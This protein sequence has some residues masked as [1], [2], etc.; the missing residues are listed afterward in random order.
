MNMRTAAAAIALA[1]LCWIPLPAATP[2]MPLGEVKAGMVGIG[3]TVFEGAKL[4]EFNVHILGVLHNIQ[5][6]H[7][8]LILA[9]LEGGPL[10]KTGVAA[11][12]SGSP[13]YIDGRLIGAVSYSIGSFPTEAIAGITPIDEMKDATA[14]VSRTPTR[15][16]RIDLPITRE[17]LTNAL[18]ATYARLAPFAN[19]PADIQVFG[20]PAAAG[21]Q[22][23]AMLRPIATPLVMSGF[24][25]GA[26][27]MLA[28][29][30]GAAG[31]TPVIGGAVGGQ[32]GAEVKSL[33]GPLREGDAIGVSLVGGDLEMGATGTI[34]HIDGDRIYAFGHP[35]FGVGPSQFPMTRAYVYAMLPSLMSSFKISSMGEV[36]GTMQQDRATAIAGT[37]GK[38]PAVIPMAVTL[39]STREDGA[40][41]KRSFS[42]KVANDQVFTPLLTY[43]ALANTLTAYERQFGAATFSVK[44]RAQIKGHG[45]LTLEDV[46]TGDSATLGAATAIAGPITMLLG[47]DR[48]P[49]TL[50]GLDVSI[51]ASES[52]RTS[53]IERVWLD[54]VRPR[55]GRTVPL[56][57]LTRSYRGEEKISTVAIEIPANVSGSLSLLVTDGRQLNAMEQRELRRSLQPQS[58][59]QMIRVLND[60]R[61]NNRI[62]IRLL[63][64]RPGAVVNG[65]AL[66]A[67]PP[68]V[69]SVLEADSNGGSYTPIRSAAVGEWEL[70]MDSAVTGSR[71]LAID[72]E[73][74]TA[75]R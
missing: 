13:V 49:I 55:A 59:T 24:E 23:G 38:G 36:I 70:T 66:T 15:Q 4:E 16:A 44:S 73:A 10:A 58:V 9:R 53:T 69:L 64:G 29:A 8:D 56:K 67:L 37:L 62:Y 2:L 27:D 54:E 48:E 74:R 31:F 46:F 6:P 5:G 22:L 47:N 40:T 57:V 43:V 7:R 52:S 17:G 42:F 20:M 60:T 65:E 30:F 18:T 61:R 19:R 32:G 51:E 41:T 75:G 3:R 21:A 45:D 63:N 28:A 14:M 26:A 35:F 25:P 72:V 50:N 11:G 12:M 68:S 34:T 71:V 39:N 33:S 1:V